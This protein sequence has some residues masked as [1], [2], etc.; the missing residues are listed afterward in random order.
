MNL[1]YLQYF[2]MRQEFL[3]HIIHIRKQSIFCSPKMV[4]LF[5]NARLWEC[6]MHVYK[7]LDEDRV[8]NIQYDSKGACIPW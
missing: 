2:M 7:E 1:L 5:Q 4:M 6:Q 8:W 3:G